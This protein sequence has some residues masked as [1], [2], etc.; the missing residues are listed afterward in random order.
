MS[1]LNQK[2]KY[3]LQADVFRF[4]PEIGLKSDIAAPPFCTKGGS[5]LLDSP[6]DVQDWIERLRSEEAASNHQNDVGGA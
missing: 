1:K 6:Q 4:T 2:A 5:D 3:P